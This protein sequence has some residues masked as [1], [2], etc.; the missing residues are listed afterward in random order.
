MNAPGLRSAQDRLLREVL[1]PLRRFWSGKH[2]VLLATQ[3][4]RVSNRNIAELSESGAEVRCVIAASWADDDPMPKG[5]VWNCLEHGSRMERQDFEAWLRTSPTELTKWLDDFDPGHDLV[6]LGTTFSDYPEFCG[7]R[8][9]GWRLREWTLWEDKTRIEAMWRAIGIH[10]PDHVVLDVDDPALA[11][12][13][14]AYDHGLGVVV[15]IDN[16]VELSTGGQGLRWA[17]DASAL[18]SAIDELRPQTT[19]VRIASFVGGVPCSIMGLVLASGV[20]VFDPVEDITLRSLDTGKFLFCGSSTWWRPSAAGLAEIRQTARRIGRHLADNLSYRGFFSVDGVLGEDRFQVTE[21]NP[22]H[23]SGLGLHSA[24]PE[25]PVYLFHRAVQMGIAGMEALDW[26]SVETTFRTAIRSA[27]SVSIT[28]PSLAG[29]HRAAGAHS[30]VVRYSGL[31]VVDPV[32]WVVTYSH[33]G[34]E[35]GLIAVEPMPVTGQLGLV[36]Q[37]FASQTGRPD[38]VSH[39]TADCRVRRPSV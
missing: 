13:A 7:R 38:L 26:Q 21:L 14:L 9:H 5:S 33:D 27:P 6:V 22:R 4:G 20:A 29:P 25:F 15:A 37:A 23:A 1:N 39:A 36:M 3:A 12:Q 30:D 24:W 16:S 17:V 35:A 31:P 19:R 34:I 2:V 28:L 32:E 18:A 11:D 10:S 8:V